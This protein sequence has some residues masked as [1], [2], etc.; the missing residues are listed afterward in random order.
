[1]LNLHEEVKSEDSE[2][3]SEEEEK[4]E[5]QDP[6]RQLERAQI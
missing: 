1:M 3:E 2:E 5:V 6:A 4:V